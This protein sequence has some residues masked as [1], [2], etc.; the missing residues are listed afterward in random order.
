MPHEIERILRAAGRGVWLIDA[1]KADEILALI[2]MRL[3]GPRSD[4]A[5][6]DR[7]QSAMTEDMRAGPKLVRVIRLHGTIM[8]RGNMLSDMSGA[9][10]LERFG[11][12][13]R[14]AANDP[15]TGAIVLDIDSP[16]GNVALVPE[17]V[18]MIRAARR[19]D[20][21]IVAVANT[22]CASA[23]Y[24]IACATDELVATTS[25]TVGSVGVYM[26]HQDMSERAK[27]E[28]VKVTY[29]SQGPRKVE[30]N[31]FEP[32]DEVAKGAFLAEV[33]E[34]YN[35]FTSDVAKARGVAVS[36]VRADPETDAQ[37]FGGGRS[38]GAAAAKRLGMI[39][40]IATLD[41]TIARLAKGGRSGGSRG[42]ASIERER[43]GLI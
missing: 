36:V 30:G 10:S 12:V 8:P 34:T 5:F 14:Q 7:E 33:R 1:A 15:Q 11:Q 38:Y 20:R 42:R 40:R 16:G 39:D 24:W 19:D 23:A 22:T 31:P 25:A 3:A 18:A 9:V 4:T 27:M 26:M 13:F 37:H 32:L 2:E 21:P 29:L 17:T 41:E 43:L 35:A 6:P 28:G